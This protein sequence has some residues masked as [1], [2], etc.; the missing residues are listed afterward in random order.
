MR[1][2]GGGGGGGGFSNYDQKS[3]SEHN[4]F[5]CGGSCTRPQYL[6]QHPT[7]KKLLFFPLIG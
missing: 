6:S 2:G 3:Y 5:A 4:M 7:L 1:A